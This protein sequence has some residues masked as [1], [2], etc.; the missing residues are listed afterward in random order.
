MASQDFIYVLVATVEGS[1]TP[2]AIFNN[3][4]RCEDAVSME[5]RDRLEAHGLRMFDCD[6]F[7]VEEW[8]LNAW[9]DS[10]SIK[11]LT[12][13]DNRGDMARQLVAPGLE[14]KTR[15]EQRGARLRRMME[16]K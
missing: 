2:L 8:S 4:S 3:R 11:T 6:H 15:V 9:I 1:R 5:L 13:Y 7:T 14:G 10:S 12:S 16:K